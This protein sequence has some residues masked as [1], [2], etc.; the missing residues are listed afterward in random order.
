M[1]TYHE[2]PDKVVSG[3][4]GRSL[5]DKG[6]TYQS[7]VDQLKANEKL[8]LATSNGSWNLVI[9]L[10]TEREFDHVCNNRQGKGEYTFYGID[11]LDYGLHLD[12]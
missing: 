3:E 7:Y 4:I 2:Q 8:W 6:T 11:P 1:G 12:E 9:L 10:N 5:E